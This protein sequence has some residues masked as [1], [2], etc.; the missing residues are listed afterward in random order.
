MFTEC[1]MELWKNKNGTEFLINPQVLLLETVYLN[2]LH[3]YFEHK[4]VIYI[5]NIPLNVILSSK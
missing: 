1:Y 5:T 2:T 3:Q 4:P